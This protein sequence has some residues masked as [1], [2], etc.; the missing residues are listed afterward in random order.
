MDLRTG[1]FTP[2]VSSVARRSWNSKVASC[3]L[4]VRSSHCPGRGS[5]TATALGMLS[6]IA[7]SIDGVRGLVG[8]FEW[9]TCFSRTPPV[10]TIFSL[11]GSR[12]FNSC[13]SRIGP[14]GPTYSLS[15]PDELSSGKESSIESR[16]ATGRSKRDKASRYWFDDPGLH[17]ITMSNSVKRNAH[18][19]NLGSRSGLR[20]TQVCK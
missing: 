14:L 19:Y 5:S 18:R 8:L 17:F 6:T 15:L 7:L 11:N 10:S 12:S 16:A 3:A 9:T 4:L 13:P 1:S 20:N 2:P